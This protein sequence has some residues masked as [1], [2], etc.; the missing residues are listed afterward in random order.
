MPAEGKNGINPWKEKQF[1]FSE[2]IR[3][4]G[5]KKE[6]EIPPAGSRTEPNSPIVGGINPYTRKPYHIE[7]PRDGKKAV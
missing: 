1:L 4:Q 2:I 5:K 3:K 7:G 6:S